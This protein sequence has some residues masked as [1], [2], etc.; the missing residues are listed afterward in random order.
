MNYMHDL[1]LIAHHYKISIIITNMIRQKDDLDVENL[2]K[3]ISI[4]THMKIKLKKN[5]NIYVGKVI[6]S[7]LK[8]QEFSYLITAKGITDAS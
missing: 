2:D 5:G 1:S 3:S 8:K 6:P 4:F 7:F